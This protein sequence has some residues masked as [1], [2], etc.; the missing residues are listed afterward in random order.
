MP[1]EKELVATTFQEQVALNRDWTITD[2]SDENMVRALVKFPNG[3]GASV[4][5]GAFSYGGPLGL[6]ELGVVDEQDTLDYSTPITDDVLGY[7][8]EDDVMELL[9][10]IAAL[11][12]KGKEVE[13]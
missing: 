3:R 9:D 13:G 7:L 2:R 5:R 11:P 4:I 10:R 12:P 1:E 8:D 6:Y